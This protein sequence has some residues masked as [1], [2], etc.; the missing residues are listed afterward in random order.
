MSSFLSGGY[1][2]CLATLVL[3]FLLVS[4]PSSLTS[5]TILSIDSSFFLITWPNHR[6][7]FLLFTWTMRSILLC[8]YRSSFLFLCHLVT[9]CIILITFMPAVVICCSSL[10]VKFTSNDKNRV[11][12]PILM[13]SNGC[14]RLIIV[15]A[16]TVLARIVAFISRHMNM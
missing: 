15:T 11:R 14:D 3:V 2:C 5:I 4:F 10:F 8:L 12:S 1:R 13:F 9:P 16:A 6:R 7:L